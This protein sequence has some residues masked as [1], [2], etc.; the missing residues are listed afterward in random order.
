MFAKTYKIRQN[1]TWYLAEKC[2]TTYK[3]KIREHYD[4]HLL[5]EDRVNAKL[6]VTVLEYVLTSIFFQFRSS[7]TGIE[8][9]L[10]VQ[11]MLTVLGLSFEW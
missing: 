10:S 9:Y 3:Y 4:L 8:H 2:L 7:F 5:S 1:I 11:A 6:G